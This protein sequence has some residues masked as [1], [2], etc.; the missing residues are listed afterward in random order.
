MLRFM[1]YK[2]LYFF[3]SALVIVPGVFSLLKWG[4][5]PA[6]DFTGGTLIE[7]RLTPP[8]NKQIDLATMRQE[9]EK[10]N[11][12]FSSIQPE[13]ENT[14]L[15]RAKPIDQETN[16]KLERQL[17]ENLGQTEELRFEIVGPT[18]GKELLQKTLVALAV[19]SVLILVFVAYQFKNR[20]FGICAILAMFHDSLV[21]LGT[22][23]LLGHFLG[24]EVDTLFVTAV[25]TILSF[26]VH[27]TIVVY[28]RIRESKKYFPKVNFEDLVD[29]AVA[30][31]LGRSVN[32]SMTVIF[33]L[34][35]LYLLGGET[36]KWFVFAL[37]I[38]TVSG[39]YSSTFTAAPLLVVW[40]KLS[41]RRR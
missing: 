38:G 2:Y 24:V 13:G 15:V 6:I 29:K 17:S 41:K 14:F 31:T 9:F 22:F 1:K 36:T 33:M 35:A 26:S 21:V 30:E 37:L 39:T 3:I 28:D 12:E 32:N 23:S 19:A 4:L 7:L 10:A 11:V 16:L 18:L 5:R 40:E 25:L 8:E 27:D 34:L 20:M